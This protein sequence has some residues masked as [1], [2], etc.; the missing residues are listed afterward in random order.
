MSPPIDPADFRRRLRAL[1]EALS[2]LDRYAATPREQFL[3]ERDTQRMALHALFT[4]TQ[5]AIDLALQVCSHRR[6]VTDGTYRDAFRAL[7]E[8]GWLEPQLAQRLEGWASMRNVVTHFDPVLDLDKVFDTVL[9]HADLHAFAE[10][11][12]DF[13]NAP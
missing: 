13:V 11:A 2:D 10:W 3:R 6:L 1:T 4:A 12:I 8:A 9:E 5:A 7:G